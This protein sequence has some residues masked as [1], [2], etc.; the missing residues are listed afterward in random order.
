[1]PSNAGTSILEE[2]LACIGQRID[3]ILTQAGD[4]D[5]NYIASLHNE[6]V[7]IS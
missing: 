1:M 4:K 6:V 7:C 3:S 5:K 2:A